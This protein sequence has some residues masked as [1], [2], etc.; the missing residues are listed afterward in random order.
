MG[1]RVF[2]DG[3]VNFTNVL[4]I[5]EVAAGNFGMAFIYFLSAIILP[6]RRQGA[7]RR[8]VPSQSHD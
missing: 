2:C 1:G 3:D 7:K 4:W 6:I 8:I 5:K